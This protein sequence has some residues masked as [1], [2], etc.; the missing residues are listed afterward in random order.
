MMNRCFCISGV[1]AFDGLGSE[2]NTEVMGYIGIESVSTFVAGKWNFFYYNVK[3]YQMPRTNA[4]A[5]WRIW[6]ERESCSQ[7]RQC[8]SGIIAK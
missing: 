8:H 3:L 5:M 1:W 4:S 6:L 7:V 2:G